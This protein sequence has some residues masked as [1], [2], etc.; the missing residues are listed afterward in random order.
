M[1]QANLLDRLRMATGHQPQAWFDP[2]LERA[3]NDLSTIASW[4][5][6]PRVVLPAKDGPVEEA[7]AGMAA[8]NGADFATMTE[9]ERQPYRESAAGLLIE[10][11]Q[12]NAEA[13][14]AQRIDEESRADQDDPAGGLPADPAGGPETDPNPLR[15]DPDDHA[16][17]PADGP[18]SLEA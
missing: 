9:S 3:Y 5:P 2:T 16:A 13:E 18:G 4:H 8:I 10:T 17:E 12:R 1:P 7:A 14:L 6:E 11:R 15:P